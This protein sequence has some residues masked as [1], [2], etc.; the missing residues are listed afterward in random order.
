MLQSHF[1]IVLINN[2][3]TFNLISKKFSFRIFEIPFLH[4]TGFSRG[5][6]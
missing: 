5:L 4:N 6:H 2:D 1:I 3:L